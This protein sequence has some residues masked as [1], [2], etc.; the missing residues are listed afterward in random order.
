MRLEGCRLVVSRPR[1]LKT[2]RTTRPARHYGTSR[3]SASKSVWTTT[4]CNHDGKGRKT[5]FSSL[6]VHQVEHYDW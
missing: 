3:T 1:E 6:G 4:D 2:A 5:L